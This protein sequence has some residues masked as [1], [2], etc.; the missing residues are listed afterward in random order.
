[1]TPVDFETMCAFEKKE[2]FVR[3]L[4]TQAKAVAADS[5]IANLSGGRT[6]RGLDVSTLTGLSSAKIEY[7]VGKRD[8]KNPLY[9]DQVKVMG[10][11][12]TEVTASSLRGYIVL[13]LAVVCP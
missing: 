12:A 1:M 11:S 7:A 4:P 9:N 10:K 8:N 5:S 13:I 6:S 2:P 3:N